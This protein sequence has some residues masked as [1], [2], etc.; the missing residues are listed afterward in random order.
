MIVV[1]EGL[2]D[3]DVDENQSDNRRLL[4]ETVHEF[5]NDGEGFLGQ[6]ALKYSRKAYHAT[7]LVDQGA[8]SVG[9]NVG[10]FELWE[11]PTQ[12][13]EARKGLFLIT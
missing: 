11:V 3:T 10:D 4:Q 6:L 8:S 1:L 9:P 5:D 7:E 2:G 13:R 12:V